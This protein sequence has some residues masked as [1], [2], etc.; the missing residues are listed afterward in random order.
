M[1]YYERMRFKHVL[2]PLILISALACQAQTTTESDSDS[3]K[4]SLDAPLFYQL[5]VGELS[6]RSEDAGTAFSLILDAAR[7]T[8]D[9]Q[10]FKRA[11]QIA[12]Q[13]RS[14]ESALVAAQAW[15]QAIPSSREANRFVLQILLGLNRVADTLKPLQRELA[16][17]PSKEQRDLIWSIPA[18]YERVKDRQTAASTVQ[19]ALTAQLA[20]PTTGATAWASVGRMWLIAGDKTG[21]LNAASKAQVVDPQSEHAALLALSMMSPDMPQAERLVKIHLPGARPEFLMAYVKTLLS[22]Q[23]EPDAKAQLQV[24]QS[25]FPN[26]A[27]SWLI[28]GA[29]ALQ[30][31]QWALAEKHTQH[32]L[33]LVNAAQTNDHA[34]D[35][36]RGR[37]QAFIAMAQIAQQ[38]KDL[39]Q[40]IAW[41]E[42]VDN[43]DDKLR[44]QVRKAMLI[45]QLGRIDEAIDLIHAQPVHSEAD[46]QLIRTG[47]IQI[48]RDQKLFE[49]AREALNRFIAQYPDDLDLVY[50]LAMVYEK[51][52]NL[53]DMEALLR[54]LMAAKPQDP[55]AFNALG[56]SLADRNMRLPEAIALITKALELSPNDP[57]ITD[58]LAW[59]EF[60]S[61]RFETA[62]ILLQGAFKAKPDPEIAAH[63]GEILWTMKRQP[64]AVEIFRQGL[65]IK[66]DNEVLTETIQRLHVP[67]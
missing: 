17:T 49:R 53:V 25:R 2:L 43:P 22:A 66:P 4:S 33:D 42:L 63:L 26:Y 44:S 31:G 14:G 45:A 8:N 37:T 41:L 51:L 18:I 23:R 64:E 11:V 28:D 65:Q 10:V 24:L 27:D 3:K 40:A 46:A 56:Y 15:S 36:R 61:G 35:T 13:A 60:R 9:P 6:A 5:L 62:L 16:L 39:P 47:E 54:R 30:A 7:K 1:D 58:S 34:P 52:G 55:H 19:K 48:L 57:L 29:L 21:A 12:L 38:R 20:S 50:D 32:Y 67:L 59:A